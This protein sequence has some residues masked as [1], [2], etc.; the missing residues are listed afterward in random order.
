MRNS[1]DLSE[2]KENRLFILLLAVFVVIMVYRFFS[3][4]LTDF[5]TTIYA[6][7]YKYG[8][9]SRAFIGSAW[10]LL[11]QMIP[12]DLMEHLP[13][14]R[15]NQIMTIIYIICFFAF[16]IVCLR[17]TARKNLHNMRY[18][19]VFL[20]ILAVPI[21][22]CK[23][24]FGRIDIFLFMITLASII[25]IIREKHEWLIVPL[26]AL[27]MC[28]HHGFVFM[29]INI[30]LVLLLYKAIMIQGKEKKKYIILFV[31]TCVIA[32]AFFLY[33]EFFSHVQDESVFQ[34]V[35][36]AAKDLS[37][38]GKD[39]S[40]E[41]VNHEILGKGVFMDEWKYHVANYIDVPIFLVFF[42]PYLL[43][44]IHFLKHLI[45][46]KE[47]KEQFVYLMV[48]LGAFTVLPEMILKVDYGRYV[49]AVFFYYIAIV[50]S[51]IAMGDQTVAEQLEQTKLVVKQ[52][53]PFAIILLVYPMLFVPF[54]D[55]PISMI[56]DQLRIVL[57][58]GESF[59]SY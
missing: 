25:L 34:E 17:R 12:Y 49:F 8:F 35:V 29:N 19:I 23:V 36:Q 4:E 6:F 10:S 59:N 54:Y 33:F 24:N 47:R 30:I 22:L 38:T 18:L 46:G 7:S 31:L 13:I 56:D 57:F 15:F 2:K 28:I 27:A 26:C 11:N 53:I 32:S 39:Y 5:N 14:Y 16:Y 55:I 52:K 1:Q 58:N 9:I 20:T 45:G 40:E 48:A 44:G 43:I 3:R 50:M 37:V 21:F 41:M 42:L 51:L